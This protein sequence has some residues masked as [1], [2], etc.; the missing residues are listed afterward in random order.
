M[1]ERPP[2]LHN[3]IWPIATMTPPDAKGGK[4]ACELDL[5]LIPIGSEDKMFSLV[6]YIHLIRWF[7]I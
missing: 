2:N 7:Y 4:T 3:V 1:S 6:G 5:Y